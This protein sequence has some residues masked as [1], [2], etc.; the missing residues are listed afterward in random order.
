ML[1]VVFCVAWLHS[2]SMHF[3]L[4]FSDPG[5]LPRGEIPEPKDK[6]EIVMVIKADVMLRYR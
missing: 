4:A 6:E 5:V 3:I 2:L 1:T